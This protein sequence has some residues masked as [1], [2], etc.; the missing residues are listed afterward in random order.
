MA[1]HPAAEQEPHKLKTWASLKESSDSNL[2][3][4]Q[5]EDQEG[6]FEKH[7]DQVMMLGGKGSEIQGEI[8]INDSPK[9]AVQQTQPGSGRC[10]FCKILGT[11]GQACCERCPTLYSGK[12]FIY[13]QSLYDDIILDPPKERIVWQQNIIVNHVSNRGNGRNSK[14]E[15][16]KLE[17]LQVEPPRGW[18]EL[19]ED[20]FN[21][22]EGEVT[23]IYLPGY[24]EGIAQLM[25]PVNNGYYLKAPLEGL[26]VFQKNSYGGFTA[27][28]YEVGCLSY[29]VEGDMLEHANYAKGLDLLDC[30]VYP[31]PKPWESAW[32][33]QASSIRED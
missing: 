17:L 20:C 30:S 1:P 14:D 31:V 9:P 27:V 32:A 10:R 2:I 11:A 25:I 24:A 22:V 19:P 33:K 26:Q 5:S 4:H 13:D 6:S 3:S 7:M 12:P 29:D 28:P 15:P 21:V 16:M 8:T 23:L 18:Q